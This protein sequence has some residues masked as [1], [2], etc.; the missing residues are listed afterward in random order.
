[1]TSPAGPSSEREAPV[2]ADFVDPENDNIRRSR[3]GHLV[4]LSGALR[5][6]VVLGARR[7]FG[8]A[9][10][11]EVFD[12]EKG[13]AGNAGLARRDVLTDSDRW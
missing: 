5:R 6:R 7:I 10:A 9:E 1:V 3:L 13:D 8:A 12:S 4:D 2:L 11:E